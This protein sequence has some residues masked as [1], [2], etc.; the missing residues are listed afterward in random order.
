MSLAASCPS[1]TIHTGLQYL[2]LIAPSVFPSQFILIQSDTLPIPPS[3]AASLIFTSSRARC[4]APF[5]LYVL[6]VPGISSYG[7]EDM[8]GLVYGVLT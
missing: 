8:F 5:F 4:V 6:R 3:E 1:T 7:L 2:C